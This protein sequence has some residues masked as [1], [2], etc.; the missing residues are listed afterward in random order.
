MDNHLKYNCILSR[1]VGDKPVNDRYKIIQL[2]NCVF[3]T[4]NKHAKK[5]YGEG[6]LCDYHV[7]EYITK[8]QAVQVCTIS[9]TTIIENEL[10]SSSFEESFEEFIGISKSSNTLPVEEIVID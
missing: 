10:K 1:I 5:P 8:E 6:T 4:L 9:K 7:G 3:V 2:D